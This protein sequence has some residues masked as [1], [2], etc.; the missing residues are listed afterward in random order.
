MFMMT[1][2][3]TPRTP[4]T[5]RRAFTLIELLVVIAIIAL[6]VSIILPSLGKARKY[7]KLVI[8]E[9]N[10]RQL[11]VGSINYVTDYKDRFPGFT[12]FAGM[13]TP[14]GR[15]PGIPAVLPANNDLAAAAWQAVDI[16]RRKSVPEFPTF[17]AQPNWIPHIRYSHLPLLDYLG[18]RLPELSAM[19][20]EDAE[21]RQWFEDPRIPRFGQSRL[22]YS[23]TYNF[24]PSFY[25]PDRFA[26]S[27]SLRQGGSHATYAYTFDQRYKLG[28]RK[29]SDVRSPS[30]KIWLY[31]EYARH[32]SNK[33]I[34]YTHP[35]AR[36]TA[37]FAD[38]SARIITTSETNLG[39]YTTAGG[40]IT[41]PAPVN[42]VVGDS[43]PTIPWPDT[44]PTTQ[45]GRYRWTVGGLK[46]F[47]IGSG[48]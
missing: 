44:S 10:Q 1:R 21:R 27:G 31:D 2:A 7:A 13:T 6:L 30:Q 19:C 20:S 42:Y 28:T 26:G 41:R 48:L 3:R 4:H 8:C 23:A 5:T 40:T 36:N 32:F 14:S 11:A 35:A 45:D 18:T 43:T 24:T 37:V 22:P 33:P 46:G 39:G 12:W 25:S 34:Y 38:G 16:I 47:D 29:G 15:A 17:P 9:I